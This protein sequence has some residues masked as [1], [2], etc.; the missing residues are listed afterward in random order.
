MKFYDRDKELKVLHK[1][2][3]KYKL[4]IQGVSLADM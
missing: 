1:N 3:G 4:E 2:F